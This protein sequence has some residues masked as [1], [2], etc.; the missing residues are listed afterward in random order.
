[1]T[2]IIISFGIDFSEGLEAVVIGSLIVFLTKV[3]SGSR[4]VMYRKN[5][6]FGEVLPTVVCRHEPGSVSCLSQIVERAGKILLLRI[7]SQLP[8]TPGLVK[9]NVGNDRAELACSPNNFLPFA[10]YVGHFVGVEVV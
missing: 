4:I 2:H 10:R 5:I 7:H 9:G 6:A 1:M 3:A 8:Y